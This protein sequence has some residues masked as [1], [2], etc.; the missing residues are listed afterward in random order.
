MSFATVSTS[1]TLPV[2]VAWPVNPDGRLWNTAVPRSV[3]PSY[4]LVSVLAI[5]ITV[6]PLVTSSVP[7]FCRIV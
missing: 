3:S 2:T 5:M 6:S 7:Y 4:T 1:A